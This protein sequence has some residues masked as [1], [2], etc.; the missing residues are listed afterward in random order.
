MPFSPAGWLVQSTILILRWGESAYQTLCIS[1]RSS[2]SSAKCIQWKPRTWRS[3]MRM[4]CRGWHVSYR[5]KFILV[6]LDCFKPI[7]KSCIS[8]QSRGNGIV[9]TISPVQLSPLC[10]H[11]PYRALDP[12]VPSSVSFRHLMLPGSTYSVGLPNNASIFQC[13]YCLH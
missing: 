1:S 11:H 3:P 8:D 4:R 7:A 2:F 13:C 5:F 12:N 10:C 9:A 6:M